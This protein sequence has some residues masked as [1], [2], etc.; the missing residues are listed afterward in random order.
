MHQARRCGAC[1][2]GLSKSSRVDRRYCGGRCRLRAYYIRERSG[3]AVQPSSA[4]EKRIQALEQNLQ[5]TQEALEAQ[6]RL[7]KTASQREQ[8]ARR[9][10]ADLESQAQGFAQVRREAEGAKAREQEAL[11]RIADIQGQLDQARERAESSAASVGQLEAS[12][13]QAQSDVLYLSHR[14]RQSEALRRE[15]RPAPENL[16]PQLEGAKR[17]VA[18][19]AQDLSAQSLELKA[20]RERIKDLESRPAPQPAPAF[21]VQPYVATPLPP[22]SPPPRRPPAKPTKAAKPAKPRK[23]KAP[24]AAKPARASSARPAARRQE[25][26]DPPYQEASASYD[27]DELESEELLAKILRDYVIVEDDLVRLQKLRGLPETGLELLDWTEASIKSRARGEA[28][29]RRRRFSTRPER[30]VGHRVT[31]EILNHRL[32]RQS[33]SLVLGEALRDTEKL[34]RKLARL[35]RG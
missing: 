14:L 19:L 18:Q 20:A 23:P 31:W 35:R 25:A 26:L 1:G 5:R 27:D 15:A 16:R 32:D 4:D 6:Q 34:K 30:E 2:R 8:E 3:E 17:Q 28:F 29:L 10:V 11:R 33:E 22:Q 12:L 21:F 13:S 9:R 7:T 24:K